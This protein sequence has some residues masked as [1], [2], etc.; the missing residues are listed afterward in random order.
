MNNRFSNIIN[1]PIINDLILSLLSLFQK[2]QPNFSKSM[3]IIDGFS[4]VS[5]VNMAI[6][7]QGVRVN[8]RGEG[9][10]SENILLTG[11]AFIYKAA[12]T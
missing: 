11:P 8:S 5:K 6:L 7:D 12:P 2:Y 9:A 3:R 4:S 10:L 1:Q